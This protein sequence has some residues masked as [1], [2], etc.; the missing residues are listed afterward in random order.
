MME[1]LGKN[2]DSVRVQASKC[3]KFFKK[4]ARLELFAVTGP[5]ETVKIKPSGE[6]IAS[7]NNGLLALAAGLALA[8][9]IIGGIKYLR[10]YGEEE[11]LTKAKRTIYYVVLGLVIILIS[12]SVVITLD[13]I[14]KG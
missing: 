1:F 13:K 6:L 11:A 10:S 14:A 12:Y 2:A 8:F 4:N 3:F 5:L 9:L 7:L